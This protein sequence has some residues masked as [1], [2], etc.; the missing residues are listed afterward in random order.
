MK[1]SLVILIAV[2]VLAALIPQDL[3]AG[4]GIKGGYTLSKSRM[5]PPMAPPYVGANL[6]YF[7]GGLS[8]NLGLG[9]VS[10][11]PEILYVRSG[12]RY[13]ADPGTYHEIWFDYIQVPVLLKLNIVPAGPIRPFLCAG[14]YGAYLFKATGVIVEAGVELP[15][16]D[17]IDNYQKLDYGVVGGAGLTFKLPG[18]ALTVEG[19]YNYGLRNLVIDPAAGEWTKNSSLMALV[20][21]GF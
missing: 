6:P 5:E 19:R 21:I 11:Q 3:T 10:I 12:G 18:I 17:L 13:V 8:F 7:A 9:F 15:R 20:G 2:I 4:I 14:G 1:K 16:G